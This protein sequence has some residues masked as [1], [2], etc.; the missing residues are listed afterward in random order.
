MRLTFGWGYLSRS[1]WRNYC[2]YIC[3]AHCATLVF[4][5]HFTA[6]RGCQNIFA[7]LCYFVFWLVSRDLRGNEKLA[8]GVEAALQTWVTLTSVID[9]WKFRDGE[10]S[11]KWS[12]KK[13]KEKKLLVCVCLFNGLNMEGCGWWSFT[14][15]FCTF[16][17][18]DQ[19]LL[20]NTVW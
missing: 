13:R 3:P 9:S 1:R 6:V 2:G 20:W 10:H 11:V 16:S 7:L 5:F 12:K 8:R 19:P 14:A 18:N 4:W 17:P 15:W